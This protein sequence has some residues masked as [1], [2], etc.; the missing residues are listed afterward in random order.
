[1]TQ[2]PK[3]AESPQ[4]ALW[5]GRSGQTWVEKQALLD[6]LLQP[7]EALLVAAAAESGARD[8]LDIG[9]GTGATTL[10]ICRT[11][12]RR[13]TGVDISEP[14]IRLARERAAKARLPA[15]FVIAD[16]QDHAF[17]PVP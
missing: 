7:F 9:C 12:G 10:A 15:D 17:P 5:N 1:M 16:A 6:R 2:P 4:K 3:R 13:C 14:M 11:L 8:V